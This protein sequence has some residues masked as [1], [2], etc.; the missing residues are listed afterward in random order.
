MATL[1]EQLRT[2]REAKGV[3]ETEAGEATNIMTKHI[4]AME[5]D[6]FSMMA[7]PTYA[8]GFIRLYANYLGLDPEPLVEE[9]TEHHGGNPQPFISEN[10]EEHVHPVRRSIAQNEDVSGGAGPLSKLFSGNFKNL[11]D[12][13]FKDIRV[14]AGIIASLLVLLTLISSVSTCIQRKNA[15]RPAAPRAEAARML[16]DEPLPNLYLVEPGKIEG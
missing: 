9:Y 12:T 6:D 5:V 10:G 14:I 13:P 8:K 7:A 2:A 16:L 4:H 1:G 15:N 11:S 3:S